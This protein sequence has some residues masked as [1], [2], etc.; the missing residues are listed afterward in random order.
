MTCIGG[1]YGEPATALPSSV[2]WASQ[3]GGGNDPLV[4]EPVQPYEMLEHCKL[5]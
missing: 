4:G 3:G 1:A 2:D 5:Q